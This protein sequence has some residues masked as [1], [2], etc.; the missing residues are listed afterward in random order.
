MVKG[1][2]SEALVVIGNGSGWGIGGVGEELQ[3]LNDQF[4]ILRHSAVF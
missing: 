3:E 2:P 1:S 4:L